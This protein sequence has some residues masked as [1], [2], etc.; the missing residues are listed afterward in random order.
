MESGNAE[1]GP[2]TVHEIRITNHG[3]IASWVSFALQHL[4]KYEDRPLVLHTLPA[5]K[6]KLPARAGAASAEEPPSKSPRAMAGK[7]PPS[8][9]TIPRLVSVVEI[10]K[11]EYLKTIDPT[12]AEAGCLSG[13]HQY[14]E[15][16]DVEDGGYV[17]RG[18]DEEARME[19][20]ARA[21]Q[22]KNHLKQKKI[23]FMRVTLSRKEIPALVRN[24]A[25]YQPPSVRKLSKSA[26]A[27][28]KKKGRVYHSG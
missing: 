21:L 2:S 23:A 15:I 13:L 19:S 22:G 27:R 26:R 24:G 4:Q 16:G 1:A 11:R 5:A 20:L 17:E 12:L 28:L 7:L 9:A 6:G 8:M 25:T 18:E 10:I 3:K 14:N